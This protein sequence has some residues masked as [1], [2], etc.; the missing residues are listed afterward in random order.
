MT[1][2]YTLPSTPEATWFG[3]S[4]RGTP[5]IIGLVRCGQD[6]CQLVP[7]FSNTNISQR[8][9][10]QLPNAMLMRREDSSGNAGDGARAINLL[11]FSPTNQERKMF[12]RAGS[13]MVLLLSR[14]NFSPPYPWAL[15]L[16]LER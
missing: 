8:G 16:Q 12:S 7:V 13:E 15:I 1:Q 5:R 14:L 9:E 2:I 6:S 11:C 10:L 4:G 3:E